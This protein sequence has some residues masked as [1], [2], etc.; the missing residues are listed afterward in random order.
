MKLY[1]VMVTLNCLKYT[2]M[3]LGSFK[4]NIPY[5]FIL[6]DNASTDGT[7]FLLLKLKTLP[8]Y[9]IVECSKRISV[10]QAW[11]M[12]LKKAMQDPEFKYAFVINNDIVFEPYCVDVLVKFV[13][14]HPEYKLVSGFDIK[15]RKEL[16][17]GHIDDRCEFI[18]FLI[19]KECI[20]KIGYFDENFVGAYYED[21]DY[22]W[23]VYKAG[24]KSCVV[25]DAR[26]THFH[27]RTLNEG[28]SLVERDILAANFEHNKNYFKQK[29]GRLPG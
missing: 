10:S 11:N 7:Y 1:V 28:L 25:Y 29:W 9:I 4:T 21:N 19:T 16:P 15:D 24:L 26:L 22:H 8:N 12:A 13:E 18:A 14:D 23:R 17:S 20:E 6:I 5:N 3:T 27:S 2:Q